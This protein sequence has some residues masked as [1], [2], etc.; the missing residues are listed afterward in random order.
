ME[1]SGAGFSVYSLEYIIP[2]PRRK[3][4]PHLT[5]FRVQTVRGRVVYF[6]TSPNR[7]DFLPLPFRRRKRGNHLRQH[8]QRGVPR[9]REASAIKEIPE[10][11]YSADGRNDKVAL[12]QARR[13]LGEQGRLFY[14]LPDLFFQKRQFLCA[15]VHSQIHPIRYGQTEQRF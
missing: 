13:D 6:Q 1:K 3:S 4:N 15:A 5:P 14:R 9:G 12:A 11:I 2:G 8:G 7:L 10:D